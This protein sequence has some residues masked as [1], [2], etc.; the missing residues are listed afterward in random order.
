[1]NNADNMNKTDE[2]LAWTA[3][4]IEKRSNIDLTQG[5][6]TSTNPFNEGMF[7]SPTS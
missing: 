5:G 4:K 3:P 7:Y 1:M 6:T 2:K